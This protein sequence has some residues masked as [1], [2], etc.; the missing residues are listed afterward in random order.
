MGFTGTFSYQSAPA[1][2]HVRGLYNYEEKRWWWA[3]SFR[4]GMT[5][6]YR[7]WKDAVAM[8]LSCRFYTVDSSPIKYPL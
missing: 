4:Y 6:I 1:K 7:D 8:A 5:I 2:P 3:V